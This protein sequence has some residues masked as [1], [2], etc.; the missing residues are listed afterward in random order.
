[1][2]LELGAVTSLI[3]GGL[4]CSL[5][6]LSALMCSLLWSDVE[7]CRNGIG[8]SQQD[9]ELKGHRLLEEWLAATTHAVQEQRQLRGDGQRQRDPLSYLARS[10][11]EHR[12]A[13]QRR[14]PC[15][16]LVLSARK[17]LAALR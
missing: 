2:L 1:V 5:L 13:R 14:Q 9:A 6:I 7:R 8:R 11:D 15:R 4:M 3:L 10:P 12:G 17:G 16:H